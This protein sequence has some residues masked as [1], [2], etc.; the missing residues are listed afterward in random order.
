MIIGCGISIK[1][2]RKSWEKPHLGGGYDFPLAFLF[3]LY[4]AR[5]NTGDAM[6]PELPYFL[7][8]KPQN[9]GFRH[10]KG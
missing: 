2:R 3:A 1:A 10:I 6:H 9:E 7:T 4:L 5:L 8:L